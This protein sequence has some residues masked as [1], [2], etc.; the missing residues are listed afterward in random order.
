[1]SDA[2]VHG[3]D[4]REIVRLTDQAG[5]LVDLLHHDTAYN[6]GSTVLETGCGVGAQTVTLAARSPDALFTS[7]DVSAASLAEAKRRIDS[8]GLTNVTFQQADVFAL[9][10]APESFDHVFVCFV[11]EH[12]RR[13]VE[14]LAALSGVLRPGGTIVVIEGDHGSAYFHPDSEAAREAIACQVDLQRRAGGDALI[15]RQVYPLMVGA[16][17]EAVRV[18]P[19]MVYVDSSR[20]ELVD[21]FTRKTFT[22]MIEGVREPAITAGL[23]E[24]ERF[25]AG[26]RGLHRTTEADGVFCYTFFKGVG[27]KR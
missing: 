12:L 5:T 1:M 15:G 7:I 6:A 14:A 3:Y 22:A 11:L 9:P 25:D 27:E 13:P 19:R 23:I 24:P 17:F 2:Y 8:A 18:S 16:G 20:P 10:F 26:V 4:A 21:G